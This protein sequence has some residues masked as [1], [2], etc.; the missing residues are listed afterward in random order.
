MVTID[1]V[2]WGQGQHKDPVR[3][4]EFFGVGLID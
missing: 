4:N 2:N 3:E 1:F